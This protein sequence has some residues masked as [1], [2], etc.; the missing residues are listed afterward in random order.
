MNYAQAKRFDDDLI[1][2]IDIS[3]LRDGSDPLAVGKALHAAS[4][5]LGFIYIKG[6]GI[7][8][9][10]IETARETALRFFRS[11]PDDKEGI[12]ISAHHRGWLGQGGAKMQDDAKA[13]LKESFIWGY[14]AEDGSVPGDHPLRG[15]N[16]WPDFLPDM[17]SH[18]MA[19]FAHAH[20]VAHHL[21]RGFALGLG[22]DPRFFLR[23]SERPLSRASF[24]Y[25]PP[26]PE[27]MGTAQFGVGPH[28][29]FG[30]LTVLCQDS[31]GG[32]QVQDVNGDWIEA[33]PIEGSLIV[34]VG[35]LLAR[36]TD[37][38]YTSTP[39]R[40]VNSSGR[41]RLSLVLAF[42]PDPE[43]V[44]DAREIYGAAHEPREPATTC[45]DYLVWRFE[46][47]FSYR[48]A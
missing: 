24:V 3:P 43:T 42:D 16:L 41:E 10:V 32:L 22:L 8:D 11:N 44:I 15:P 19:Y 25:Y 28:T 12:R 36:W 20:E 29:D 6:H 37:H 23:N 26:Q 9:S 7:P 38:A 31:V 14:Q 1:P 47:A 33:P 45:G 2:V 48:K 39:H 18:A 34:N 40:V 5:G 21:M 4:S 30:V 35:D 13:D 17:Q 27:E 46:K